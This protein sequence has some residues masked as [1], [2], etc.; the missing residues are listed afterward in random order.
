M[1]MDPPCSTLST[2]EL[3]TE[4]WRMILAFIHPKEAFFY[5]LVCKL[6]RDLLEEK[7]VQDP[8]WPGV[9]LWVTS[10]TFAIISVPRIKWAKKN[11][12]P[13]NEATCALAAGTGS[14]KVL[15]WAR[16]NRCPWDEMVP[17][18]AACEGNLQTLK[19][20]LGQHCRWYADLL[21]I[22]AKQGQLNVLK[23]L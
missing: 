13:W 12:L 6:W 4:I 10:M 1:N 21:S 23:W 2:V 5:A 18:A 7:K 8:R 17:E 11:G 15:R 3:P 16:R 14:V 9:P 19:W 20:A 22:A